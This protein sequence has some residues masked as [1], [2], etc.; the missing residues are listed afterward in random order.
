MIK[1]DELNAAIE[2]INKLDAAELREIRKKIDAALA[3]SFDSDFEFFP[4]RAQARESF[5]GFP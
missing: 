1:I 4:S 2:T 5:R 3:D